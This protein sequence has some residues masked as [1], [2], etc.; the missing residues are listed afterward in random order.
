MP[1][2]KSTLWMTG[3]PVTVVGVGTGGWV[4]IKTE[5]T[6]VGLTASVALMDVFA[7]AKRAAI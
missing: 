3:A 4:G 6:I 2:L 5:G 1:F 7:G